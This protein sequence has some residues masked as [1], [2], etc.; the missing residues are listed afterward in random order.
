M[1]GADDDPAPLRHL[2][3]QVAGERL[4]GD[5]IERIDVQPKAV[6]VIIGR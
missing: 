6:T 2:P 4:V 5:R 1:A 3:L